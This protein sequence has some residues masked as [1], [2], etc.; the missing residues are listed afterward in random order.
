MTTSI[1]YE[2]IFLLSF[3][4]AGCSV[5]PIVEEPKQATFDGNEQNAGILGSL[6]SGEIEITPRRREVIISYASRFGKKVDATF[7]ADSQIKSIQDGN[8]AI[9]K[10]GL[11]FF[12]RCLQEE[13]NEKID[14]SDTLINKIGL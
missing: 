5:T 4:L 8:Y 2:K 12:F 10:E 13:K 9:T 14:G 7:K 1:K 6:E 11:E 3:L